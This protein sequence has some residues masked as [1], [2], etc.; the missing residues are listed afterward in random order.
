M[1]FLLAKISSPPCPPCKLLPVGKAVLHSCMEVAL[2]L[3][4][5]LAKKEPSQ[6]VLD[7][8][9]CL[10]IAFLI[11]G[12]KCSSL[13]C[14][15]MCV[16]CALAN[17]LLYLSPEWSS[18]PAA[19]MGAHRPSPGICWGWDLLAMGDKHSQLK[20]ILLCLFCLYIKCYPDK[21]ELC[22]SY[23]DTC[24][25]CSALTSRDDCSW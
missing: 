20:L 12:L 23:P 17:L 14:I 22:L 24:K 6:L 2:S 21:C 4:H 15:S 7:L 16:I 25:P 18:L 13:F 19:Q 11:P 5:F 9:L 3:E 8:S 10:E 1:R